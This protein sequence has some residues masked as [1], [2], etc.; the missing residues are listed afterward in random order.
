MD[1]IKYLQIYKNELPICSFYQ[2]SEIYK[3]F[4]LNSENKTEITSNEFRRARDRIKE[5][6]TIQ[7]EELKRQ[8]MIFLNCKLLEDMDEVATIIF[9]TQAKINKLRR[10]EAK[11]ELLSQIYFECINLDDKLYYETV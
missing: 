11:I 10:A 1:K 9:N 3:A 2:D 5:Q 6:L 7:E 4:S 8:N